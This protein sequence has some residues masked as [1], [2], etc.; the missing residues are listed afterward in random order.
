ML[1]LAKYIS[2]RHRGNWDDNRDIQQPGFDTTTEDDLG[3]EKGNV[4][5]DERCG[6][7]SPRKSGHNI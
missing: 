4:S 5:G 3:W 1:I 2:A 6:E 7:N